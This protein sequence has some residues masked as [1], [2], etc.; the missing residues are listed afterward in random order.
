MT[1]PMSDERFADL[2]KILEQRRR[3]ILDE[4]MKK[5]SE[6]RKTTVDEDDALSAFSNAD[7]E[8]D[9]EFALVQM[10]GETLRKINEALIRL[11]DR[12]FGYCFECGGEISERRL[13]SLPFAVRCRACEEAREIQEDRE[14]RARKVGIID[15]D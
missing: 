7:V 6:V 15:L 14:R 8:D 13:K 1:V 5:V 9:I 3:E 10:K 4:V 11:E 2:K 12:K